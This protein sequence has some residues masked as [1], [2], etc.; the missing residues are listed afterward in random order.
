MT[1]D[2]QVQVQKVDKGLL[3]G[4]YLKNRI[5]NS[6]GAI[7]AFGGSEGGCNYQKAE[8]LAQQG[9][10]VLALYLF[11][12]PHLP[13]ELKKV[14]LEIFEA[15]LSFIRE[16]FS[17]STSITVVGESKGAEFSL[18]L[19]SKYSDF[20]DKVVGIVPSSFVFY[21]LGEMDNEVSSW[22]QAG[23]EIPYISLAAIRKG[24]HLAT[25]KPFLRYFYGTLRKKLIAFRTLYQAC[26][27]LSDRGEEA[28][29]KV[30]N[31]QGDVLLIA[32]KEDQLWHSDKMAMEIAEHRGQLRTKVIIYEKAGH[33]IGGPYQTSQLIL[34]GDEEQSK[35]CYEPMMQAIQSFCQNSQ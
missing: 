21:G 26:V 6:A 34:G 18:L 5:M 31:F 3:Q 10:E 11:G 2:K 27:E 17:C 12:K 13:D 14:P 16:S 33:S 1:S 35:R 32:G 20:I 25:I 15:A 22:T 7:L 9:Y 8:W 30:E 23:V 24:V 19:A 28:R 4:Y 29:I